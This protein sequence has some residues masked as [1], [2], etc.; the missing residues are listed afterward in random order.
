MWQNDLNDCL[1]QSDLNDLRSTGFRFTWTNQH[2]NN[3][4]LK[5]PHLVL[6]N[7]K[8]ECEFV[9]SETHFL[10]FGVLDHSYML[11]KVARTPKRKAPFKCFDF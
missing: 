10:S 4:I 11:V 3:P 5:K 9:G 7:V 1:T 6:V 8:W 2:C